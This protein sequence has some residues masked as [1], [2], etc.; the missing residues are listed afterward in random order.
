MEKTIILYHGNCPDGFGGAYAAW[1]KFGDAA[2][3]IPLSRNGEPPYEACTG[4][5]LYFIDFCYTKEVMDQFITIAKSVTMLDHHE[6]VEDV[7]RSMPEYRYASDHSGAA[8]AWDYFHPETPFPTLLQHVEDD[9]LFRFSLPD[10]RAIITFLEVQPF[11]FQVWDEIAQALDNPSTRETMLSRATVYRE[12][13][14]RLA[15]ISVEHAK[16]VSFEGHEVYFAQAHPL[17]SMKSLVGNLLAKKKGPCALVIS[18]HPNGYGVSIR[19]D[20]SVD[21]S[22]IAQKFGGNGHPNSAGFLIRREG[23]FPWTI[24]AEDETPRD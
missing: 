4:A 12:Y 7:I 6:G 22:K 13:F 20:G 18:A 3:Y 2:E 23:P 24:I 5:N 10:T 15:A 21:V 16:L 14:E 8:I 17:K 11:E 1:K 9:D 19:G